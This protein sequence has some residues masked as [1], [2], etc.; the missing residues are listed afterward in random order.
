[1]AE[2][3][4]SRIPIVEIAG[5]I[6]LLGISWTVTSAGLLLMYSII[7][8]AIEIYYPTISH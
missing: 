1:M 2:E 4:S 6:M 3:L 5:R 7:I 8:V